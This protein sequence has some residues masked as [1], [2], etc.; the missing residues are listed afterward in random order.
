MISEL[1]KK[2]RKASLVLSSAS[3]EQKNAALV[4]AAETIRNRQDIILVEN[5]KDIENAKAKD[6]PSAFIDRLLLT[7]KRI[8]G[9]RSYEDLC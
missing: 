2:A 6:Y 1:G 4:K 7:E 3:D 5:A 8:A 9:T